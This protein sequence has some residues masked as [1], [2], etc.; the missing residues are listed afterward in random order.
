MLCRGRTFGFAR[1]RQQFSDFALHVEYRM[2]PKGNSGAQGINRQTTKLRIPILKLLEIELG[3]FAAIVDGVI[4]FRGYLPFD[5][6]GWRTRVQVQ[7]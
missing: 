2:S 6:A 5:I 4:F 1:H 3:G 7:A